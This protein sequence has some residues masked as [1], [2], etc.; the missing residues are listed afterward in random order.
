MAIKL[1][2]KAHFKNVFMLTCSESLGS[3]KAIE[4][5]SNVTPRGFIIFC[6]RQ[7]YQFKWRADKPTEGRTLSLGSSLD[8]CT[9]HLKS[10][11]HQCSL[12]DRLVKGPQL[13]P[14]LFSFILSLNPHWIIEVRLHQPLG[15]LRKR[16]AIIAERENKK[17][18]FSGPKK[19]SS[20]EKM[21]SAQWRK[22][23]RETLE[24]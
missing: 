15:A 2:G 17:K 20:C 11:T 4:M 21:S 12:S 23:Q 6:S 16:V 22:N 13:P 5:C 8:D 24:L 18:W 9:K 14:L 3:W 10:L 19:V 1:L 7:Q